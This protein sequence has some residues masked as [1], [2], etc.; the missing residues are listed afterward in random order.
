MN[1]LI[2]IQIHIFFYNLYLIIFSYFN[3]IFVNN[4][5]LIFTNIYSKKFEIY[6]TY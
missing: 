6:F 1:K 3:F 5:L 2:Y 4:L